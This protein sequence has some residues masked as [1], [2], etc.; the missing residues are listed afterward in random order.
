MTGG[1]RPAR[2][3]DTQSQ[4]RAACGLLQEAT[5]HLAPR[6]SSHPWAWA[7]PSRSERRSETLIE[8]VT[9]PFE[10]MDMVVEDIPPDAG[11]QHFARAKVHEGL[12]VTRRPGL[13]EP[14]YG[15]ITTGPRS[16]DT[17]GA[18]PFGW[19]VPGLR[20]HLALRAI[21]PRRTHVPTVLSLRMKSE[22]NYCHALIDIVGGK[23]RLA[24][25]AGVPEDVPLV[26]AE[27]LAASIYFQGLRRSPGLRDREWIV[28]SDRHFVGARKIFFAESP[29]RTIKAC[30]DYLLRLLD[31]P[32]SDPTRQDRLFVVRKPSA[33]RA[34]ANQAEVEAVCRRFGF[35]MID[36]AGRSL[37]EQM[38]MFSNV[39]YV[40]AVH[41]AGLTNIVFRRAAPLRVMELIDPA[42]MR[43]F[44][45][46]NPRYFLISQ[47]CGFDYMAMMGESPET[48]G[49]NSASIV[50]DTDILARKLEMMS[51]R[52]LV[53]RT[54]GACPED[55][56][57]RPG[58]MGGPERCHP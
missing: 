15:W 29:N 45:Y 1:L 7:R 47:F 37:E 2:G 24:E 20:R 56:T 31:V 18:L 10:D 28:Q 51:R 34:I 58:V 8:R 42:Y 35:Q 5:R 41:G 46:P 16:L 43:R 30:V 49:W 27:S 14:D 6:A 19:D 44:G 57:E 9:R 13:I 23:L 55:P 12:H 32:Q 17:R 53:R 25:E 50:V 26:V 21:S 52:A 38:E 54:D 22:A 48:T 40:V 3:E 36:T 11:F 33:V 39:G 4:V